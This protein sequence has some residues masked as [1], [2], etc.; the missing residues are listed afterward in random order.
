MKQQAKKGE[1]MKKI[2][3]LVLMFLTIS[4]FSFAE[5][6]RTMNDEIKTI[7]A[8]DEQ[9]KEVSKV[10]HIAYVQRQSDLALIPCIPGNADYTK[11]LEDV[12][13]GA[14]VKPFDYVAEAQR[15][16]NA[17]AQAEE[18]KAKEDLIQIKIREQAIEVLQEEG[19]LDSNGKITK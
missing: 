8:V 13:T 18:V 15:Q 2:S 10:I 1:P 19:K 3:L 17:G 16:A 11:Y 12:K 5:S 9:G 4:N 14:E 7:Q 6:Y